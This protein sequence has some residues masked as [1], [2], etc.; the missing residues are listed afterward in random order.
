M[1]SVC[2]QDERPPN[3]LLIVADDQGYADLGCAGLVDDV[4]TPHLDRLAARGTRF[5]QAYAA[6]PICNLSRMALMTGVYPLRFGSRWYGGKGLH[7]EQHPTL[8]E[9]FQ[10]AGYATG[11]VGKFH[12][13]SNH[14]PESRNFPLTHGF[15]E[16]Y[17]CSGGR[18]H[19]LVHNAAAEAAFQKVKQANERAGQS[20]RMDPMW[21]GDQTT[22]VEGFST[23]L[24]GA[25]A[26]AFLDE[27]KAEPFLLVLAFNAV[28][29]FTHQLPPEYLEA[30]GLKGYRDWDPAKEDYYD[31]YRA[32][33]AP[34]NPEGREQYLGQLHFLDVEVGRVLAHLDA[35]ELTEDTLVVYIG[36]NGGSTPIYADNGPLR[37]SKYTLYEGGLRV[38]LVVSWPARWQSGVLRDEVVSSM[39]LLPTLLAAARVEQPAVLDGHDLA[40]ILRGEGS[41]S[42]E[43]LFWET[44]N[45]SAARVGDL[46]W[47]AATSKQ[48]AD[49]EMVELELGEFLHDLARD[50]GER[51]NLAEDEPDQLR[52]LQQ[53]HATWKQ[54]MESGR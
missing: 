47:H 41:V 53:A 42:H 51:T 24:F 18:K 54:R 8:G 11:Y 7:L 31:W 29:N 15:E 48:H 32:G 19:Y 12:Y 49:Y 9:C 3:V 5:T 52:D 23:E 22:D 36:D 44:G 10:R 21:V 39:D 4:E 46:K 34:N 14:K 25:R 16:F 1:A 40:V 13:G 43:A 6:S 27:H 17:G 33:R 20:L 37:G 28:H 50:L 38:P 30:Q 45:E 2:A 35:L 26:R